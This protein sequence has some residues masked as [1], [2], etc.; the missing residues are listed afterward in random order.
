MLK[1]YLNSLTKFRING[2]VPLLQYICIAWYL[3]N[4]Q[5]NINLSSRKE[6][7]HYFTE[8]CNIYRVS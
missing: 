5:G 3:L 2:A 7:P 6:I 4:H 8:K 1:T